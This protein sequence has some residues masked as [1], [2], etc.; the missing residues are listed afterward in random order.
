MSLPDMTSSHDFRV[1]LMLSELRP[2]GMERVVL[3]LALGLAARNITV[4]V[5]CLQ[6][7]GLLSSE[8]ENTAVK[9]VTINSFKGKDLKAIL[10][11]R[12]ELLRFKPE[13]INLHDY[14]SLPYVIAAN[15]LA[16]HSPVLFSAHG[17][18]YEGFEN[19]KTRNRFFSRSLRGVSAVSA[20][21]ADRHRDYL[22]WSRPIE[23]ISN[24]VPA[25]SCDMRN[26][27]TTR[28]QLG[29]KPETFLFLAVGNPRPEKG[30]EDLIEAVADLR[31]TQ[32]NFEDL[33]VVVAG[34]LKDDDYCRMVLKRYQGTLY[35]RSYSLP[36]FSAGYCRTL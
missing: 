25:H 28:Q 16:G 36:R 35:G 9:L 5:I 8:L 27:D 22:K 24:G 3:H 12:Q 18:L 11:L 32:P 26:R 10:R 20:K 6:G 1:A 23:I 29:C 15:A 21:V 31:N 19:K 13:L 34:T 14:A 4:S 33:L 17:L 7:A 30:F 2:G